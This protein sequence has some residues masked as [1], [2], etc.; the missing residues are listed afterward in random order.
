[1]MGVYEG[2]AYVLLYNG[3][4][5]DRR[6]AGGNV[7]TANVLAPLPPLAPLVVKKGSKMRWRVSSLMPLPLSRTQRWA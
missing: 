6:P 5:G 4:L 3:I 7:L 2:T 1:M